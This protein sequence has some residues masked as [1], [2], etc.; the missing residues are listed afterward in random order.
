MASDPAEARIPFSS[1]FATGG[2]ASAARLP[3]RSTKNSP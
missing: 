2:V 1:I 3:Y